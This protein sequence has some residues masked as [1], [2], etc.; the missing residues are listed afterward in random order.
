MQ[1]NIKVAVH[2]RQKVSS[3]SF[4]IIWEW[5]LVASHGPNV[6]VLLHVG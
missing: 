5:H 6:F 2:E 3:V 4:C 1:K